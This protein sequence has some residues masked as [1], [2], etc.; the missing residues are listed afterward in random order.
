MML[1]KHEEQ[2]LPQ[3]ERKIAHPLSQWRALGSGD[4]ESA[5]H[6]PRT[7]GACV[8]HGPSGC[9]GVTAPHGKPGTAWDASAP[10][11]ATS[12]GLTLG[13]ATRPKA[14]RC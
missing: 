2:P 13:L 8:S 12:W 10:R 1:Q 7:H 14:N 6:A 11:G 4:P 3:R 5:P 9:T